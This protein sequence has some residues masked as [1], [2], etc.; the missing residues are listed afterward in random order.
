MR[1]EEDHVASELMNHLN[2]EVAPDLIIAAL[3]ESWGGDCEQENSG[4]IFSV[5]N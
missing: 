2:Q 1:Q 4:K 3:I 5:L